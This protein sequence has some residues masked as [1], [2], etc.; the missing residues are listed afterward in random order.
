MPVNV[1]MSVNPSLALRPISA[2][3]GET[4][5]K[6]SMP[7]EVS[8]LGFHLASSVK[9]KIWKG[10]LIDIL[11]LLH[12]SKDFLSKSDKKAE[13]LTEE[14]KRRAIPTGTG[15]RLYTFIWQSWEN[16]S[17]RNAQGYSSI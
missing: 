5:F 10:D 7:C 14:D 4:S 11:S 8:P 13:D 1:Q 12:A 3:V 15:Y 2:A 9:E 16:A 17:L 6:E